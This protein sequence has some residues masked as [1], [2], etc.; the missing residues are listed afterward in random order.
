MKKFRT[1]TGRRMEM[2]MCRMCLS[3]P[4]IFSDA[5]SVIQMK[6]CPA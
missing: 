2:G 5:L 1:M 3:C 6:D 4:A